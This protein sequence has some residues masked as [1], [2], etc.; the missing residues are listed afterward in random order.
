[1]V[2]IYDGLQRLLKATRGKLSAHY[3][4]IMH[5]LYVVYSNFKVISSRLLTNH[6][7]CRR[8]EKSVNEFHIPFDGHFSVLLPDK[9]RTRKRRKA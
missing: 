2:S 3:S 4:V 8:F 5:D 6:T 9:T 7:T 1:M